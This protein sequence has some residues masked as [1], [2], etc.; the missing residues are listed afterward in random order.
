MEKTVDEGIEAESTDDDSENDGNNYDDVGVEGGR[1]GGGGGFAG[2]ELVAANFIVEE[3][4]ARGEGHG[5][6]F[7]VATVEG[8]GY[9]SEEGFCSGRWS[10]GPI[11]ECRW[12]RDILI[13][14]NYYA[15]KFVIKF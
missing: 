7:V 5:V 11:S 13:F 12:D 1:G 10:G 4:A 8:E 15:I 14:H 3:E 6:G 2:G 9:L